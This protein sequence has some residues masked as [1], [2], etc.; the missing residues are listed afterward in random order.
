MNLNQVK[1]IALRCAAWGLAFCAVLLISPVIL[2][3]SVPIAI[4]IVS[5]VV[6]AGYGPIAVLLFISTVGL[7][8]VHRAAAAEAMVRWRD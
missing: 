5:D 2:I 4:G 7:L 8:R 3:Y 6:R 1:K